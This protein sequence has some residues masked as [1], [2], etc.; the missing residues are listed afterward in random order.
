M[1]AV[2]NKFHPLLLLIVI[3]LV[4]RVYK[5]ANEKEPLKFNQV[6]ASS[7]SDKE[8]LNTCHSIQGIVEESFSYKRTSD[9][10]V[11]MHLGQAESYCTFYNSKIE[12]GDIV[13]KDLNKCLTLTKAQISR[14]AVPSSTEYSPQY[15]VY[16]NG[17]IYWKCENG[18][19]PKRVEVRSKRFDAKPYRYVENNNILLIEADTRLAYFYKGEIFKRVYSE[20]G[21][22]MYN[23]GSNEIS[24]PEN[25]DFSPQLFP[26]G[27]KI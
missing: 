5:V 14:G 3:I 12:I 4:I 11:E 7:L 13:T 21:F 20:K 18:R 27:Q 24:S 8:K 22:T 23:G 9:G 15:S 2:I 25:F 1:G 16:K 6:I 19:S 26:L 10:I 17:M